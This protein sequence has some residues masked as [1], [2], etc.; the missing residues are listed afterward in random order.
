MEPSVADLVDVR[1][2]RSP[3][4]T[5]DGESA[6]RRNRALCRSGPAMA[7]PCRWRPGRRPVHA[8][9][10]AAKRGS[11]HTGWTHPETRDGRARPL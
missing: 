10:D 9:G 4:H 1:P 8:A 2:A 7:D 6:A 3:V 5:S 11:E